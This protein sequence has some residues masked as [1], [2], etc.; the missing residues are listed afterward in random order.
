MEKVIK[1]NHTT[2]YIP[3]LNGTLRIAGISDMHIDKAM[4]LEKIKRVFNLVGEYHPDYICLLGDNIDSTNVIDDQ[5]R[6]Q[7]FLDLLTYS[8]FI[9]PTML[10]LADHD[11]RYYD[12]NGQSS[13]DFRKNFWDEVAQLPNV[14]VLNNA[15]YEDDRVRF[16]GYTLP[17]YYYTA[18]YDLPSYSMA[19]KDRADEDLGVLVEDLFYHQEILD[20]YLENPNNKYSAVLFHSPQQV[21]DP[22]VAYQLRGF[23][24]ILSGHM[25]EGCVPPI[26]DEIIPGNLGFIS[27]Q[28]SL[29][30]AFSRG[31]IKT[32]YGSLCIISGG[33]TKI[34]GSAK[35]IL[36]PFN[37]FFPMHI[38]IVDVTGEPIGKTKQYKR[39]STYKYMK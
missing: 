3:N 7:E 10:S 27:P 33:I 12:E 32:S 14:H 19:S 22:N 21:N 8:G 17:S 23:N 35:K 5:T 4:K 9:A 26:L 15:A 13:F 1:V 20:S 18:K 36:Q 38:D 2:T 30:P 39:E 34:H 6:K 24:H 16:L 11:Q 37:K 31:V 25:H 28:R 29:F